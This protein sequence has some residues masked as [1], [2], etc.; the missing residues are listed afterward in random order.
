MK[1]YHKI[2]SVFKRDERTHK[3]IIGEYSLPEF[4]YLKNNIWVYT[5]KI[6]GTNIR[7][8]WDGTQIR[9]GGKTD[10]AQT[11]TFLLT[12]L[13][14]LFPADKFKDLPPLCLYGEGYGARIQKGGGNYIPNG[15]DFILIDVWVDDWWLERE[16]IED[17]ASKLGI[18]VVP[19][20]GKGNIATALSETQSGFSSTFGAFLAEGMVLKPQVELFNRK[21]N[22]IIT[23]MK[24]KDF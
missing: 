7:V 9:F 21:G 22:R 5:E 18:K 16:N 13:Q 8:M 3:F 12:K 15:C 11:P 17:V 19:I 24:Y 4:G 23:K 10:N 14:D 2:Q 20:I 6:D 1:E